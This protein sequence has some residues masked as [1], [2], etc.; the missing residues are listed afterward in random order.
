MKYD[1][2]WLTMQG[3]LFYGWELNLDIGQFG[4]FFEMQANKEALKDKHM[5]VKNLKTYFKDKLITWRR[6][7]LIIVSQ[8]NVN[9]TV[10]YKMLYYN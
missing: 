10:K 6:D 5:Y 4:W 9:T 8:Q 3:S 7:Q 1:C 2:L